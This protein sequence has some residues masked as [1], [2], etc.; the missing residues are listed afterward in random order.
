[1]GGMAWFILVVVVKELQTNAVA[2]SGYND[3]DDDG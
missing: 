1:M 3:D 2:L